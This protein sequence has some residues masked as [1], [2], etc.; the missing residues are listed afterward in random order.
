MTKKAIRFS[1]EWCG[2]C[3]AYAPIF[4]K[5]AESREDWQFETFDVDKN[6]DVA[7]Q[8]GIRSIPTTIL[9]VDGKML[10]KYTGVVSDLE[11]KLNEWK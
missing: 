10:A 2:P 5:V 1:A 7:E 9:E 8:Y 3:K 4:N 6:S 11:V